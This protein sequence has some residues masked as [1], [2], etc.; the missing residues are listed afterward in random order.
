MANLNIKEILLSVGLP[1]PSQEQENILAFVDEN[2]STNL[3]V[4]ARAGTGKSTLIE[5]ILATLPAQKV[6]VCAF[7]KAIAAEMT[8]RVARRKPRATV[9]V[10]T[11]HALGFAL[12][13]SYWKKVRVYE[14]RGWE[15]AA[16][17][18]GF[19]SRTKVQIEKRLI[20]AVK[21]IASFAKGA[22]PFGS[23]E[24]LVSIAFDKDIPCKAFD[25]KGYTVEVL[26]AKAKAAMEAARSY[27]GTLDFDDMIFVPVANNWGKKLCDRLII[28]ECQDMNAGQILLALACAGDLGIIVVGDDKQAIYGFRGADSKS[29]ERLEKELGATKLPLS[30]TYRCPKVVVSMAQAIVPDFTAAPN[31][32]DGERV[33]CSEEELLDKVTKGD[34]IISRTNAPLV[35][36]CLRLLVKDIPCKI[37]GRNIGQQLAKNVAEIAAGSTDIG[38]FFDNLS[39]WK[40]QN[41]ERILQANPQGKEKKLAEIQDKFECLSAL[42]EVCQDVPSLLAKLDSLFEDVGRDGKGLVTLCSTHK[43]KGLEWPRVFGLSWTFND[44]TEEEENLS[45]VCWTRSKGF[46]S[47]VSQA[48]A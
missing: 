32:P 14:G 31:A 20:I 37:H 13:R 15:L 29:L 27:D 3:V 8:A 33:D 25:A 28:D 9:D 40:E 34:V 24:D 47:L 2:P 35:S 5:M 1:A 26:A 23:T 4:V 12:L 22:A 46:I 19:D 44:R 42:A 6:L 11:L 38:T 10:K 21:D 41:G 36:T 48:A 30:V 7:N 43:S 18:L 17:V 45:Y 39:N 16:K